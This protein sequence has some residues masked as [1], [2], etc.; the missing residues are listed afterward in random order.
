MKILVT[1]GAGFIGS[2]YIKYI[3]D[4]FTH[5]I[6]NLD[7]L[8]YA[9]CQE[10]L[11]QY[12]G[13]A[14]YTFV[15]GDVTDA[16]LVNELVSEVDCIVHFAA[17]SHVDRSISDSFPFAITNVLGTLTLLDAAHRHGSKRFHHIS[18]DEV[19]GTLGKSGT[20]TETSS[21]SP[22]S[23]YAASK[24]SAD[25]FVRAYYH[26]HGLPITISHCSNNYGPL[27]H[28]EKFI[29]NAITNILEGK[30]VLVYGDGTN[31]RDWIHVT[32]HVRGIQLVLDKG[33]IG[34]TYCFGGNAEMENKYVAKQIVELM[35]V[36]ESLIVFTKDRKGHDFRY[37]VDI[38]KV[39][40]AFNWQPTYTFTEG[41]S[42]TIQWYRDNEMW[43]KK[44]KQGT[45]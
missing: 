41:L 22:R 26:T 29:S 19:F 23:P 8:T 30:N 20:F 4:N 34:E 37:A 7:S 35:Q 45:N 14:R 25:H 18:T 17:E 16:V 32:D 10:S 21:Y 36:E 13:N 24:A 40:Q 38:T 6:V 11:V 12:K 5:E 43:W 15:Q 1:G 2:N 33:I 42:D 44:L 27:Q 3:L 9:G 31:V 39:K 28:P